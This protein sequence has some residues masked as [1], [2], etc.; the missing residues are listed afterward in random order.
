MIT[1]RNVTKYY[2]IQDRKSHYVLRD[3]SLEIPSNRSIAILGPNGAGK[4][5]LLRLI[6]GAEAPNSGTIDTKSSISWPLGLKSGFQGSMTGR[7]NIEFA[8]KINGLSKTE[9]RQ[10]I[11]AVIKFAELGEFF[12]MP[13]KTYSSGMRGRL[14]FG[15]SINFDFDYYLI[16]ELTSVGDASFRKKATQEFERISQSSSLIYVSHNLKSLKKSCQSAIFLHDGKMTYYENIDDGL[17][18]YKEYVKASKTEKTKPEKSNSGE[19]DAKKKKAARRARKMAGKMARKMA[20][21]VGPE[22][23]P[24]IIQQSEIPKNNQ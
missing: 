13:L 16:D 20:R 6:G 12:D 22:T 17:K 10:I 4:S 7:Q 19:A 21:K 23:A 24:K 9:T 14:G 2:P 18:A 11:D 3:V 1:L 5:T 8:C 15:L